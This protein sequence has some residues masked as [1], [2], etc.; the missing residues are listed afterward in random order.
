MDSESSGS[1]ISTPRS[2]SLPRVRGHGADY[3]Q[4]SLPSS[5]LSPNF[6]T[7]AYRVAKV[8]DQ[9]T[10]PEDGRPKREREKQNRVVINSAGE[11]AIV[12]VPLSSIEEVAKIEM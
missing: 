7:V 4:S 3:T 11:A 8:S 6:K 2:M 9:A 10:R 5:S 12:A 1:C